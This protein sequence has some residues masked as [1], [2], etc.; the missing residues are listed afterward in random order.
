MSP[1]HAACSV[2]CVRNLPALGRGRGPL[3]AVLVGLAA[4]GVAACGAE[5]DGAVTD[6]GNELVQGRTFLERELDPP[7]PVPESAAIGMKTSEALAAAKA[8]A[9]SLGVKKARNGC[10]LERFQVV[11]GG[12]KRVV[13]ERELCKASE[14]VRT[15][16][17]DGSVSAQ[18]A[19]RDR[20]GAVDRYSEDAE[21]LVHVD[22]DF[23]GR[24]DTVIERVDRIKGFSVEAYDEEYPKSRFT[25][26]VREDRDRDGA[27]DYEKVLAKGLLQPRS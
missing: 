15:L 9:K 8:D 17:E 20:D 2:A 18:W 26:R 13:A 10:T 16:A 19:D 25:H 1:G 7:V 12:K 23:D 3:L 24:V 21:A 4:L 6:D 22:I 5:D 11:E 14:T 27:F